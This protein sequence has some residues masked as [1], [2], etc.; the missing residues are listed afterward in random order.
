MVLGNRPQPDI[1]AVCPTSRDHVKSCEIHTRFNAIGPSFEASTLLGG[2]CTRLKS[3][4]SL[5]LSISKVWVLLL[6]PQS[7]HWHDEPT[8]KLTDASSVCEGSGLGGDMFYHHP[9][10]R[11]SSKTCL[12]RNE[13]TS[14]ACREQGSLDYQTPLGCS[15]GQTL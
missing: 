15:M 9:F 4:Y 8:V 3:F 11:S 1:Y 10:T 6:D 2:I 5:L 7:L 13:R 14:L 12:F